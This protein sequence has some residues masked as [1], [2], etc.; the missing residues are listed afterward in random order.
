MFLIT[1]STDPNKQSSAQLGA[2]WD[3]KSGSSLNLSPANQPAVL[4]ATF[5]PLLVQTGD[6][7]CNLTVSFF[8]ATALAQLC[9]FSQ[10]CLHTH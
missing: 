2:G 8:T 1:Q 10:L 4:N 6:E 5:S 7:S 9:G 3:V